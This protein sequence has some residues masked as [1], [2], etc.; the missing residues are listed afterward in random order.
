MKQVS[1]G[2]YH[3]LTTLKY[4]RDG[5]PLI[6]GRKPFQHVPIHK[7]FFM[8][9]RTQIM[10]SWMNGLQEKTIKT[11]KNG[12]E[13][14]KNLTRESTNRIKGKILEAEKTMRNKAGEAIQGL[15]IGLEILERIPPRATG[16][17][18][19]L[20]YF[21]LIS[22]AMMR[23]PQATAQDKFTQNFVYEMMAPSIRLNSNHIFS[24]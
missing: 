21:L 23:A 5:G 15:R 2:T 14:K 10:K 18:F 1:I 20:L 4:L 3:P 8:P 6:G 12:I 19:M 17:A 7:D 11:S 24:K 16:H 9:T 22:W 13:C